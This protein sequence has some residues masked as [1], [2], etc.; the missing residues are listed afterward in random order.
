MR[1]AASCVFVVGL[2]AACQ[3]AGG[4][5]EPRATSAEFDVSGASN[6]P[7]TLAVDTYQGTITF[8]I[9]APNPPV[10]DAPSETPAAIVWSCDLG[11]AGASVNVTTASTSC[12]EASRT[13]TRL[14]FTQSGCLGGPVTMSS[15][16]CPTK[17]TL[18]CNGVKLYDGVSWILCA[19]MG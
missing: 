10:P 9:A 5:N 6:V 19:W 17:V 11:D 3:S 7:C 13:S 15:D 18:T 14:C 12:V 8:E 16:N 2:L 4:G 1:R